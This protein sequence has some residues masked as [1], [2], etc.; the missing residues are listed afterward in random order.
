MVTKA[1]FQWIEPYRN[2]NNMIITML[3]NVE[4][5]ILVFCD[6]ELNVEGMYK[7]TFNHFSLSIVLGL[8]CDGVFKMTTQERKESFLESTN[9]MG[10]MIRY[11]ARMETK[12][13]PH[14]SKEAISS[15][16]N[17]SGFGTRDKKDHFGVVGNNNSNN[18]MFKKCHREAIYKTH[19]DGFP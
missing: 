8:E 14:V 5:G 4:H 17:N 10:I 1:S 11:N 13:S 2:M 3:D 6:G 12:L 18:I 16:S 9:K 7:D 15:L 19:R